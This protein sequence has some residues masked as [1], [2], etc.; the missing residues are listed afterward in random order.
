M[1]P[2]SLLVMMMEDYKKDINKSI[3]GIQESRI[4]GKHIHI[5][6]G[7]KIEQN[8]PGFKNGSR[9]SKEISKGDNSRNRN[10]RKEV[11]SHR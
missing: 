2:K 3:K 7:E 9:N 1:D 8:H 10:P 11:R 4:L 5:Q 6:T